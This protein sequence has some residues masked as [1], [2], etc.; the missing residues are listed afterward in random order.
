MTL[1]LVVLAGL[2]IVGG[3]HQ[4][5]VRRATCTFLEHWLEPVVER[6]RGR[7]S[8]SPPARKVGPGR[9]RHRRRPGRHRARRA[10]STCSSAAEAGRARGP[11]RRPGTTTAPSPPSWAGPARRPSRPSPPF[12]RTVIDGAVNG[13]GGRSCAAAGTGLRVAPDRLRAQLR[14]RRGRRRRRPPRLLPHAGGVLMRRCLLAAEAAHAVADLAA[15][16]RRRRCRSSARVVV[17]LVPAAAAELHRLVALLFATA[18]RRPHR[19]GCWPPSSTS[20]AGF[21]FEVEPHRGSPTSASPGTS[22]S[23]ASRCSSS[24]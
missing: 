2:A 19:S 17:A 16:R 11:R 18:H 20:D 5:A 13:V 3:V 14:P 9:H 6:Q 12:D 1:P 15:H 7:S 8:T 10:R 24:C 23:T 4:P 21:Q 22:A